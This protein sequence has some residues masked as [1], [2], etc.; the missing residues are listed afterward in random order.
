MSEALLARLHSVSLFQSLSEIG[1]R[2]FAS[3]VRERR[4]EA[5]RL[6]F[7][8]GEPADSMYVV[9]S[10]SVKI[11]LNDATGKQVVLGTKRPGEYFGEMMLDHRPRSASILTLEPSEFAVISREDFQAFLRQNPAAAEQL[12]L[13]LIHMT[14]DMNARA[15]G[16][17]GDI[18]ERVRGY[19]QWLEQVKSIDVPKVRRWLGAKRWVLLALLALAAAQYYFLD[20]L[21]Q[22]MSLP[23][24]TVF[25]RG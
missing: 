7:E 21:L 11:F 3:R 16:G 17:E 2:A 15:R 23:G 22:I 4:L 14:R 9:L 5:D 13:N 12:I 20:T 8:E 25:T 24:V 1:L 18:G 19:I 10:G 6:V